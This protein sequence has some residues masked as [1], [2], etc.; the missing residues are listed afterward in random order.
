QQDAA[1]VPVREARA[2]E[3]LAPKAAPPAV[4]PAQLPPDLAAFAGRRPEAARVAELLDARS[5]TAKAMPIVMIDGMPGAGKTALAVHCAHA[6]AGRFPDG[7][8]YVNLRGFDPGGAVNPTEA[9]RGFLEALGM[10][11]QRVPADLSGQ[12]AMFRSLLARQRV[13]VVL[14]NARDD[15]QVRPLLPGSP[16]SMV[17]A[18][19]RNCL[20]GLVASD[21]AELLTLDVFSPGDAREALAV[22][23]GAERVAAEP[24]ATADIVALSGRLP[25]ALALVAARAAVPARRH[26]GRAARGAGQ[27][28]R[29]QRQ[30]ATRRARGLLL[31][32]PDAQP[33][34]RPPVPAAVPAP[35]SGHLADRGREP[36]RRAAPASQGPAVRADV[37]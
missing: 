30:R 8:L 27:P 7:Q 15:D 10:P 4:R 2:R 20:N 19:S 23:L 31:V 5:A 1:P 24:D 3:A 26:R 34:R 21:G 37:G 6:L 28:R 9:L 16:G 25:L 17:I 11:P 14:D 12:S 13:L 22:R 18:T 32:L 35:R 33:G 36:G 29:L